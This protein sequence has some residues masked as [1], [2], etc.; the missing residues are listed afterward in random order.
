MIKNRIRKSA[1][2]E[3]R[4]A[5]NQQPATVFYERRSSAGFTLIEI[6]GVLAVMATLMAIIAPTVLDQIDRAVQEAETQNLA[7]IAQGVEMYL[8]ASKTWPSNLSDLSPDYVP[9]GTVQL[10]VNDRGYPRYF[11]V[12]PDVSSYVNATGLSPSALADARFLLISD[13]SQ[14]ANPNIG[15]NASTFDTWWNTDETPTPNLKIHRGHVGDLFHLMSI[16]AV[17]SGGSYRLA[18]T[19]TNSGGNML[20]SV[21]NY[22]VA[23]MV[24]EFDEDNNFSQGNFAFG[25]TLVADAGYQFD[26]N[27]TAGTQWHVL[28]SH[29]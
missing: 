14:D 29:C 3:H 12:H 26:P 16:S 20:A 25:M 6:I 5:N 18:G 23:G 27:C 4:H 8:R 15:N 19:E 1:V 13:L 24:V 10:T 2:T 11:V 9:F 7:A 22:H 21:G 17:G 28:G